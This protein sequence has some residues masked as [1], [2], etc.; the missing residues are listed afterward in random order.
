MITTP[1]AAERL[2]IT[3]KRLNEIALWCDHGL[4]MVDGPLPGPTYFEIKELITAALA[5][6]TAPPAEQPSIA[7]IDKAFTETTLTPGEADA[8]DG[9]RRAGTKA[10]VPLVRYSRPAEAAKGGEAISPGLIRH[11]KQAAHEIGHLFCWCVENLPKFP[12]MEGDWLDEVKRRLQATPSDELA[13][14]RNENRVLRDIIE[15]AGEKADTVSAKKLLHRLCAMRDE[16][17]KAREECAALLRQWNDL[18]KRTEQKHR[19]W[20]SRVLELETALAAERAAR[21]RM[22]GSLRKF[23]TNGKYKMLC[24]VTEDGSDYWEDMGEPQADKI[25][26][27]L[28]WDDWR[29]VFVAQEIPY[30][31][32]KRITEA[33]TQGAEHGTS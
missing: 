24:H 15:G 20:A 21:E 9:Q 3:P 11:Y 27:V 30:H 29:V 1:A 16:L 31:D 33:L 25:D 23:T 17:A 32:A 13:R 4:A 19:E 10:T 2:T 12:P 5:T 22:E 14:L 8:L 6:P 18:D 7:D 26:E 28:S